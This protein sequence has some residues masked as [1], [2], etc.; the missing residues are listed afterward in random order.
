KIK[1]G[2]FKTGLEQVL[3]HGATHIPQAYKSDTAHC[4]VSFVSLLI[5]VDF[6]CRGQP[7]DVHRRQARA[8]QRSVPPMGLLLLAAWRGSSAAAGLCQSR[9][10]GCLPED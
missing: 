1:D 3:G 4:V 6:S 10:H 7:G 2:E 5:G 9:V 8:P